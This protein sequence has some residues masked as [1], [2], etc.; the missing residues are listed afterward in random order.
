MNEIITPSIIAALTSLI[1][2]IITLFQF[3]RSQKLQ[4]KQFDKNLSRGLTSKLYD[5][6]I[7]CYPK[8]F[9]ITD[10]IHKLKGGNYDPKIIQTALAE[11]IDWKKGIVSLV[12]SVEALESFIA[13]RDVLMRNP[14]KKDTYSSTQI[15][16]ISHR[17]KEFRK[18]LRRD[19]G[20]LFRE[21]KERRSKN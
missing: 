11:L 13:L 7:D 21:E 6:R 15:E 4:Q 2:S 5:L 18:Q 3:F 12:I 1:I 16:N 8:A 19:I 20:F 14:E 10:S 17:T 9:E